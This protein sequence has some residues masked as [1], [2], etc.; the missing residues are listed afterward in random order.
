MLQLRFLEPTD[1]D[2]SGYPFLPG[3]VITLRTLGNREQRWVTE[4][5][6]EIVAGEPELASVAPVETAV[7]RKGKKHRR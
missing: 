3:Q 5:R 7:I 6:A 2:V 1:S 4:G